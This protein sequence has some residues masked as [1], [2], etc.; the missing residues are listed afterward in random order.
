MC[1][2]RCPRTLPS[3]T[4]TTGT[5]KK[6]LH[7]NSVLPALASVPF[8][9]LVFHSSWLILSSSCSPR[10]STCLSIGQ[11]GLCEATWEPSHW[12]LGPPWGLL[13][14]KKGKAKEG[15]R[16]GQAQQVQSN[17]RAEFWEPLCEGLGP[18]SEGRGRRGGWKGLSLPSCHP[19]LSPS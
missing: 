16:Q 5:E 8:S 17:Q 10:G 1:L 9:L 14:E 7:F 6:I 4:T 19:F 15:P 3:T 18:G 2:G 12:A 11:H 13:R